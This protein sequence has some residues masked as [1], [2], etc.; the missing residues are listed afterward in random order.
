MDIRLTRSAYQL[1]KEYLTNFRAAWFHEWQDHGVD[2]LR[3]PTRFFG[4]EILEPEHT[5][6]REAVEAKNGVVTPLIMALWVHQNLTELEFA[7][8]GY[9]PQSHWELERRHTRMKS[10]KFE[11]SLKKF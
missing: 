1:L 10:S 11:S 2:P 4:R 7:R 9:L 6:V 3:A 5:L 8:H